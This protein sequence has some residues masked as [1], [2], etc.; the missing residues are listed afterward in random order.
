MTEQTLI[1][2][3]ISGL[4]GVKGWVK[5]FS[6]TE[7]QDA[8]LSYSPWLLGAEREQRQVLEG[9]RH[10]KALVARL[11][12]CANRDEAASLV[13]MDIAVGR[14]QL[15]TLSED[16]FYWVDLEGLVVETLAGAALGTLDHLFST[17]GNDVMVVKGDRERL[18]PFLWE[19]VVKDVDLV[20]RRIR[21]DWDPD[22]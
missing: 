17:P 21:V 13:G 6:E 8:I 15:P 16:E 5:I 18:I 22:F 3:R 12:G 11:A 10:G 14:Q 7:P 1:L 2:G 20:A 19:N 4:F 9:H